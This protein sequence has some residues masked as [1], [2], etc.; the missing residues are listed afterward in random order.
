MASGFES[1][2]ARLAL[3]VKGD[4]PA[5]TRTSITRARE[6]VDAD[7]DPSVLYQS[8]ELLT[9]ERIRQ[10]QNTPNGR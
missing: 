10:P 9:G 6:T 5:G 1:L 8:A 7:A 3:V 2:Y 4:D